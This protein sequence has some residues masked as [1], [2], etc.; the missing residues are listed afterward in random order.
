MRGKLGGDLGQQPLLPDQPVG[1]VGPHVGEAEFDDPLGDPLLG[2]ALPLPGQ[3]LASGGKG[4][5][6]G[7]QRLAGDPGA[8]PEFL[9]E[10]GEAV[11]GVAAGLQVAAQVGEAEPAGVVAQASGTAV[12][13]HKPALDDQLTWRLCWSR[14]Y[15]SFR[16][17]GDDRQRHQHDHR[18]LQIDDRAPEQH[19]DGHGD[20]QDHLREVSRKV[21]LQAID[22]L[23]GTGGELR[24]AGVSE[25]SGAWA[26]T[27]L[28][29][30]GPKR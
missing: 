29:E 16:R 23:D 7:G 25:V 28:D 13:D 6:L 24:A 14:G 17:T 8:D 2:E 30:L 15:P 5:V 10:G 19:R 12:V 21:G 27:L 3:L 4:D 11:A 26:Q 18:R 1:Q 20:G 9:S 22:T